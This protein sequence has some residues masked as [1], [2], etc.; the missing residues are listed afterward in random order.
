MNLSEHFTLEEATASQKATRSGLNNFPTAPVF[1]NMKQAAAGMEQVRALLGTPINVSSWYRSPSVNKAVGGV[2]GSAH[3][4]GWAI[5][6][7]SKEFGT[8]GDV[9]VVISK[10]GIKF[11]QLIH[12]FGAWVHISFSP[13]MRGQLLTIDHQGTRNGLLGIRP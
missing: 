2:A 13:E 11:D 12:E 9:C 1:A 10:S 4:F 8:P 5:D 3:T 7:T 6:F